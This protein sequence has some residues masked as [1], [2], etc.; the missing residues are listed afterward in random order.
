MARRCFFQLRQIWN[1]HRVIS[2]EAAT[3]L[4]MALVMN[5]M[6][7]CNS[8]FGHTSAV[9]LLPLRS[10][11]KAAVRVILKMRKYDPVSNLMENRLHWL[12]TEYRH[13]YKLCTVVQK[14][15]YGIAPEYLSECCVL[16]ATNRAR[17]ALRSSDS[18][19]MLVPGPTSLITVSALYSTGTEAVEPPTCQHPRSND[20]RHFRKESEDCSLLQ[21]L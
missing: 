2:E 16:T 9:H 5:R 11:Q 1:I 15:L 8:I 7:Y 13:I 14:C 18:Y 19:S 3:T 10:V 21:S 12:P 6:D 4:V 17:A 20:E